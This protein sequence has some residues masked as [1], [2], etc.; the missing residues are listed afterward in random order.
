MGWVVFLATFSQNHL[1]NGQSFIR[2]YTSD[3]KVFDGYAQK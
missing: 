1:V 2:N 3:K